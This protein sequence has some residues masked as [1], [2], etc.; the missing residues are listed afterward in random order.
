MAT[1]QA[2]GGLAFTAASVAVSAYVASMAVQRLLGVE[3]REVPDQGLQTWAL[4][5]GLS[6]LSAAIVF[7]VMGVGYGAIFA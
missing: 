5:S 3:L 2:A 6:L 7:N 4:A 1:I